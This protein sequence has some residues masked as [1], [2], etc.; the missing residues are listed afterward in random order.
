MASGTRPRDP[1]GPRPVTLE[2]LTGA[3]VRSAVLA[4]P[5]RGEPLSWTCVKCEDI[6][7][8]TLCS[9]SG[10]FLEDVGVKEGYWRAHSRS[11]IVEPC[12]GAAVG[13]GGGAALS[14]SCRFAEGSSYP[15]QRETGA[16]CARE[17]A[18]CDEGHGGPY[19]S[20]CVDGWYKAAGGACL[21]C[22]AGNQT[23]QGIIALV[24]VL[25]LV[26]AALLVWLA[27]RRQ[28]V[29][30][31]AFGPNGTEEDI[32]QVLR[33]AIEPALKRRALKWEECLPLIK[34][35]MTMESMR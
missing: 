14:A 29:L 19:C 7:T 32:A 13:C 30:L 5:D 34:Q 33:P 20:T 11:T 8:H 9:D 6:G 35:H 15:P 28:L 22:G 17:T 1:F 4:P 31:R 18:S 2:L 24:V 23:M 10:L 26:L 16:F 25:G 27:A 21:A 12:P 3:R